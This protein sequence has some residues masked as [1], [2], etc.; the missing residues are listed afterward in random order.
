V[1]EVL[2]SSF[3]TIT[4]HSGSSKDSDSGLSVGWAGASTVWLT[5][6][7]CPRNGT[8]RFFCAEHPHGK[9]LRPAAVGL[10][11]GPAHAVDLVLAGLTAHLEGDL[12]EAE[13]AEAPI[14]LE[15]STP[16]EQF[17]GMSPPSRAVAPPG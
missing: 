11:Q 8:L 9:E 4:A 7:S 2:T 14:G 3:Q 10:A 5:P 12:Q 6:P 15:L 1:L 13:H 16:P 17:H